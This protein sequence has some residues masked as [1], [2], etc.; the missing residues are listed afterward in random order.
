MTKRRNQSTSA[1]RK[2]APGSRQN[3][4]HR[5]SWDK[6]LQRL[7]HL[8]EEYCAATASAIL[9]RLVYD[10]VP[11]IRAGALYGIIYLKEVTRSISAFRAAAVDR[12]DVV[13]DAGAWGLGQ[14]PYLRDENLLWRI[15]HEDP[16]FE[17]QF[18]AAYSLRDMPRPVNLRKFKRALETHEVAKMKLILG[19]RA[20]KDAR[21][22]DIVI[23]VL[24]RAEGYTAELLH[25]GWEFERLR[26]LVRAGTG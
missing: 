3:A 11:E 14:S 21:V 8:G 16:V 12:Q 1:P 22:R 17:V 20:L 2:R 13:R 5:A 4:S 6:V 24:T 18:S 23:E 10:E 19:D 26:A 25:E 15:L 9:P 7:W